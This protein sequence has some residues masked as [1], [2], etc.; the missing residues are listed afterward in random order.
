M[1][2]TDLIVLLPALAPLYQRI[3]FLLRLLAVRA[4]VFRD[5]PRN[6]QPRIELANRAIVLIVIVLQSIAGFI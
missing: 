1:T 3:D 2:T 6:H 5:R 4:V